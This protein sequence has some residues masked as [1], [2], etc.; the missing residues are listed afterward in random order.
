MKDKELEMAKIYY[1]QGVS[2]KVFS[3]IKSQQKGLK[4]VPS[5]QLLIEVNF[6]SDIIYVSQMVTQ[7]QP[8]LHSEVEDTF[9]HCKN[10]S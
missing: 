2:N 10:L 5:R 4:R 1:V 9:R 7:A 6:I 8:S 3:I